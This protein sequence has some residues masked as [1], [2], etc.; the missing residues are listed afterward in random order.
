MTAF[1]IIY[2]V[3]HSGNYYEITELPNAHASA[4]LIW[5]LISI[6]LFNDKNHWLQ[7]IDHARKIWDYWKDKNATEAEKFVILSTFDK[8]L[9]EGDQLERAAE[10]FEKF[11]EEHP[12]HSAYANN[13]PELAR[14]CREYKDSHLMGICYS[15]NN[16]QPNP[17]ILDN[18]EPYNFLE[19]T[20]HFGVF[21]SLKD[22]SELVLPKF[23]K[24]TFKKEPTD[25]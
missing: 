9:I 19:E 23:Q 12:V 25:E 14:Y 10:L 11:L 22:G 3:E 5:T 24:N 1:T 2:K 21:T 18:K 6:K 4:P 20:E 17:W 7:S 15:Q 13:I 8:A 16:I